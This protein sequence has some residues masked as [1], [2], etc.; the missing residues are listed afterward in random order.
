MVTT[1]SPIFLAKA[2]DLFIQDLTLRSGLNGKENYWCILKKDNLTDV[3]MQT[4]NFNFL[5]DVGHGDDATNPFTLSS[6]SLYAAGGNNWKDSN[7]C[8]H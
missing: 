2:F 1:E 8:D 3:I 4:Y 7:N 5:L 6:I